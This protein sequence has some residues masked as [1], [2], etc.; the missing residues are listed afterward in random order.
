YSDAPL[1]GPQRNVYASAN[2]ILMPMI[3]VSGAVDNE[4]L[5][6]RPQPTSVDEA[7]D[8][9]ATE[10]R[11]RWGS[12]PDL[13]AATVYLGFKQ[14]LSA[15]ESAINAGT[16]TRDGVWASLALHAQ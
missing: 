16:P 1:L 2:M 11:K 12:A 3:D 5:L 8:A 10:Y 15:Y 13:Q 7:G 14:L 4:R 9:F 6:Q